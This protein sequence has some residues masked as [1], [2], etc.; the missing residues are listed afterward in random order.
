MVE[1]SNG[2]ADLD[3]ISDQ[4]DGRNFSQRMSDSDA[5]RKVEQ[6]AD[7]LQA[8]RGDV[9]DRM[10]QTQ[11]SGKRLKNSTASISIP[12][13][14]FFSSNFFLTFLEKENEKVGKSKSLVWKLSFT[15]FSDRASIYRECR[16]ESNL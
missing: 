7:D 1:N 5:D 11:P 15:S 16:G 8:S 13:S 10:W 14:L 2:F 4:S 6:T 9:K 3:T 12:D